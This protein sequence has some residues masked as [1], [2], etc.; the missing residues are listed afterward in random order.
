MN[1]SVSDVQ[2]PTSFPPLAPL[3]D[4]PGYQNTHP[5]GS[6]HVMGFNMAFCDGS[7]RVINYSID[8]T[9]HRYLGSRNDGVP[10]DGKK[11]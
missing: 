11:L 10:I 1:A 6:A 9:A 4:T 3:P 5:F 2:P 7:V 8:T